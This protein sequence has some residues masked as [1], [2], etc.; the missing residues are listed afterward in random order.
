LGG[1]QL[2]GS[3]AIGKVGFDDAVVL[4]ARNEGMGSDDG[5]GEEWNVGPA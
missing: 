5:A 4:E 3:W 1:D 2:P